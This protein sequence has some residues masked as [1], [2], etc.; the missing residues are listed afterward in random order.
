[1][2][3]RKTRSTF[4]VIFGLFVLAS[5]ASI[6]AQTDSLVIISNGDIGMGTASPLK[7][8]HVTRSDG[9]ANLLVEETS[10]TVAR[11]ELLTLK[12]NGNVKFVLNDTDSGAI[13]DFSARSNG[14]N[15]NLLG[16]G[17]QEFL[18]TPTGKFVVGPGGLANFT[19][20][21]NGNATLNGTLTQLSSRT[22][23]E[24]IVPV[25]AEGVLER[26]SELEISSWKYK[27]REDQHYGPMAEDFYS[28]YKLGNDDKHIAPSDIAG[29]ALASAKALQGEN[30]KLRTEVAELRSDLNE[31][32]EVLSQL[33][34]Q[35]N[36]LNEAVSQRGL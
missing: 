14:F 34:Q 9:R 26:L 11:R 6:E 21:E 22:A 20:F 36:R 16:T 18:I 12:N 19:V 13:W 15:V 35:M 29:V 3:I 4:K 1:V 33:Q 7:P 30:Q 2:T 25:S 17:G 5:S 28:V 24:N 32:D 23:K 27:G 8:V 31:R 10:A